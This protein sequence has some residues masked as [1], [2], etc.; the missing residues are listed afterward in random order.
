L[1]NAT[2]KIA[3]YPFT[4]LRPHIGII[5][6]KDYSQVRVA[7]LPGLI[8]GAHE[9]RGLGHQFLK[10]IERTRALC[11]VVDICQDG[12]PLQD[13]L[14]L[15]KEIELYN[16]ELLKR[17]SLL[18]ANKIDKPGAKS[19]YLT[20]LN[21]FVQHSQCPVI[22]LSAKKKDNLDQLKSQLHS[23]VYPSQESDNSENTS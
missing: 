5:D 8:E 23:I 21:Q 4:T 2:P 12:D 11:Y 20:F 7:D 22:P 10:H 6:Y 17:P 15:R 13:Y 1:S 18:V 16:S 9:N 3:S 14:I 19:R